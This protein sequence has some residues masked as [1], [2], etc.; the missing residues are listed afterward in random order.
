MTESG[1]GGGREA[2]AASI[3]GVTATSSRLGRRLTG[4]ALVAALSLT[5][6]AC[7]TMQAGA[8][9]VVGDR[10]ISVEQLQAATTDIATY[11][12]AQDPNG[13][14]SQDKVL[15]FMILAPDLVDTAARAGVGVSD[16]TARQELGKFGVAKPSSG[17]VQA[18]R[19]LAALNSLKQG[20]KA[21]EL[22]AFVTKLRSAKI[23][24]N[25]RYG[26]FDAQAVDIVAVSPDW[27][28]STKTPP[29]LPGVPG[30]PGDGSQG[31]QDDGSQGDGGQGGQAPAPTATP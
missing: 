21:E 17:A 11:A 22:N 16:D 24:V 26:T 9:A 4:S 13:S 28:A 3:A 10:R 20:N 15:L 8:A 7:G 31:G 23:S 12:K 27:L 2:V 18:L 1:V 19:G 25:P 6:S 29:G 14:V 30:V 5:A